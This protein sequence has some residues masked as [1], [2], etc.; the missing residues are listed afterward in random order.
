MILLHVWLSLI[1]ILVN[2]QT[3]KSLKWMKCVVRFAKNR[4]KMT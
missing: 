3:N 2:F 1:C 4:L